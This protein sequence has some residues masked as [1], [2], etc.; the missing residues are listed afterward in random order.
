MIRKQTEAKMMV[1]RSTFYVICTGYRFLLNESKELFFSV[2][3]SSISLKILSEKTFHFE[4]KN[5]DSCGAELS[6]DFT[7]Q[8]LLLLSFLYL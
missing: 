7:W 8:K 5:Q 4:S 2:G 6:I 3:I 1:V